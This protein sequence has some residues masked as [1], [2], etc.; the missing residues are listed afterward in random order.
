MA[1]P[2]ADTVYLQAIRLNVKLE[3]KLTD[4]YHGACYDACRDP[5]LFSE[6]L[7]PPSKEQLY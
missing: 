1:V 6:S 3:P 2:I 4:A 7:D 5:H